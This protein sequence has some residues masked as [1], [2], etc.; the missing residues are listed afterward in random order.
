MLKHFE[1][2]HAKVVRTPLA[3]YIHL[4]NSNATQP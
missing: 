2:K 3:T 1:S 4:S